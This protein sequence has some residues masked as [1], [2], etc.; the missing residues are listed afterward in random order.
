M[1]KIKLAEMTTEN[2]RIEFEEKNDAID[3]ERT[4]LNKQLKLV[5]I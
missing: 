2:R 1:Q 3:V 5:Q 4:N